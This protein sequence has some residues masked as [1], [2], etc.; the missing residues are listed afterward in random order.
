MENVNMNT[1]YLSEEYNKALNKHLKENSTSIPYLYNGDLWQIE[2]AIEALEYLSNRAYEAN[3]EDE[4]RTRLSQMG[5]VYLTP[6]IIELK[7]YKKQLEKLQKIIT[8]SSK[9]KE[10][11]KPIYYGEWYDEYKKGE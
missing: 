7:E 5:G 1:G 8:V 3:V 10:N 4:T 2:K 6:I 9:K 11:T